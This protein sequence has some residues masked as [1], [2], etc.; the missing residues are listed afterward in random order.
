[1]PDE[2]SV[3]CWFRELER[4][5]LDA[6]QP[7]WERYFPELVRLARKKLGGAPR[8]AADEEDVALSAM[9]SFF[10][11][12]QQGRFPNLSDRD[13]L[14]RLLLRM[15]SRRATDLNRHETCQRR[16]GNQPS[17]KV[18]VGSAHTG[19]E[20]LESAEII[21]D[22]PSPECAAMMADFPDIANGHNAPFKEW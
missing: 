7:L 3:T 14:W 4:G 11:A 1:M 12:A 2:G 6:A 9:N 13:D 19:P 16:G 22:S 8:R 17:G 10:D 21:D 15:T 20:E 5:N 18:G